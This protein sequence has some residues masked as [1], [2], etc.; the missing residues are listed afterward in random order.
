[1]QT[2]QCFIA[3][4]WMLVMI[5]NKDRE[6]CTYISLMFFPG[7][8]FEP[9]SLLFDGAGS[10]RACLLPRCARLPSEH[11]KSFVMHR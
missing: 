7:T 11:G 10:G 6:A 5:E 9:F 8:S 2:K 3:R 1:M 4:R